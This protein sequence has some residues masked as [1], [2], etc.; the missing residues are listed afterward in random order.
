MSALLDQENVASRAPAGRLGPRKALGGLGRNG[1]KK[2]AARRKKGLGGGAGRRKFGDKLNNNVI[3]GKGAGGAGAGAGKKKAGAAAQKKKMTAAK[4]SIDAQKLSSQTTAAAAREV[5]CAPSRTKMQRAEK[6]N[7]YD[8]G[9]N[10]AAALGALQMGA[11]ASFEN[12]VGEAE[13]A[14]LA[15]CGVDRGFDG[16]VAESGPFDDVEVS[17]SASLFC[18][19]E[20]ER[21]S[22][23]NGASASQSSGANNINAALGDSLADLS[24]DDLS[25]SDDED[26]GEC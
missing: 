12:T 14:D 22:Q 1:A 20:S 2:T 9:V 24:F 8:G 11:R 6:E 17:S 15:N 21:N 18:K 4:S 26:D 25:S 16:W 7:A 10:L 19:G 5:E 3:R 23:G 13:F